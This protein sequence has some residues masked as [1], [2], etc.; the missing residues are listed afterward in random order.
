MGRGVAGRHATLKTR[1]MMLVANQ[2]QQLLLRIV[3]NL[4]EKR[5]AFRDSLHREF[6]HRSF[7]CGPMIF[8][9]AALRAT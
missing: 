7:Q 6:P 9:A 5:V 2:L 4:K 3:P 8:V 1:S